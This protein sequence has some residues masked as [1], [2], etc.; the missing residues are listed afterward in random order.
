[1]RINKNTLGIIICAAVLFLTLIMFFM[2]RGTDS[3]KKDSPP[4]KSEQLEVVEQIGNSDKTE[5]T[6]DAKENESW[7][8]MNDDEYD[9]T[10][11]SFDA[12]YTGPF[13]EDGTDEKVEDVLSLVFTNN[14]EKAIQY[15]EYVFTINNDV[16]TF[17]FSNLSKGQSCVVLEAGRH[18]YSKKGLL[19][20]QSRVV[21]QV[22]ELPFAREQVLVV[23][24]SD[25]TITVMNLTDKKLPLVRVFYKTFDNENNEFIGGITYTAKAEDI[26]AGSG[27]TVAPVHYSSENSVVVGSGLYKKE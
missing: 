4:S 24:N 3:Q 8:I 13:V 20:L 12:G 22:D 1:M 15:G 9:V 23:D 27:V 19:K 21:A 5:V 2:F 26:P 10:I 25:N 6:T 14:S 17:K 16:V 7:T 18:E 11:S